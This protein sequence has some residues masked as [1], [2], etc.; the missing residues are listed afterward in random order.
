MAN[1]YAQS[2]EM[3]LTTVTRT[4]KENSLGAVLCMTQLICERH[5]CIHI[6]TLFICVHLCI[7]RKNL[8]KVPLNSFLCVETISLQKFTAVF[9]LPFLLA[10]MSDVLLNF[11]AIVNQIFSSLDVIHK[12][13]NLLATM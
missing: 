7:I 13:V 6:Y 12:S 11:Y 10:G 8:L 9:A 1:S 5:A 4:G 2:L 3:P